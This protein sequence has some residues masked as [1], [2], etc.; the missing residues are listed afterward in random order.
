M[1]A[2]LFNNIAHR[3][4]VASTVKY[5]HPGED[6]AVA[7]LNWQWKADRERERESQSHPT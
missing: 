1:V 4:I 7:Q 2:Q 3:N 6:L 5:E